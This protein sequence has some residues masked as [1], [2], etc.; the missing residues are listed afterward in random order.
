LLIETFG[1][2]LNVFL[3]VEMREGAQ[4]PLVSSAMRKVSNPRLSPDGRWLAFDATTPAGLPAVAVAPLRRD[5]PLQESEWILMS[6]SASHPFWS[7]DGCRL[8]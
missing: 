6:E 5:T 7:R 4:R 3:I 8:Y 2:G 1:S